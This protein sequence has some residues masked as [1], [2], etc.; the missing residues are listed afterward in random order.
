[1]SKVKSFHFIK[2]ILQGDARPL[3]P[4][5]FSINFS[6]RKIDKADIE[7]PRIS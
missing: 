1:M 5:V 2:G 7:C 6:L 3:V 4:L